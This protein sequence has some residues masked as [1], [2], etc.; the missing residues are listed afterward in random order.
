AEQ[1]PVEA[2][3]V[4]PLAPLPDLAAHEEELLARVRP[5][6]RVERTKIRKL[7]PLVTGHPGEERTL[8][9][10]D[11]VVRERQHEVLRP[12]VQEAEGQLV[13]AM[14]PVHRIEAHI[15]ED[16]VHPPQVPLEPDT[17]TAEVRRTRD[18]RPRGRLLR[19]DDHAWMGTVHDLVHAAKK[20]DGA[21]I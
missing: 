12:G 13:V 17:E 6:E 9:M 4:M 20:G 1:M 7:L 8:A 21:E 5:H 14:L 10:H 16:V 3:V 19:G 18:H 11:L 2:P 15:V